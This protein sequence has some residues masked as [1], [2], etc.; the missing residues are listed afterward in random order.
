MKYISPKQFM[1]PTTRGGRGWTAGK[2]R[3]AATGGSQ[4]SN[5][6][7]PWCV[8]EVRGAVTLTEVLVSLFVMGLGVI[9]IASLFPISIVRSIEA[10]Q[11]TQATNLRYN[12]EAQIEVNPDL[13]HDPDRNGV[14]DEHA[15]T[16][17]NIE[18]TN[19]NRRLDAGEDDADNGV[20]G[21]LDRN[22]YV[23]DPLGWA[24][25]RTR[26]APNNRQRL[27]DWFGQR[28][29]DENG[30]PLDSNGIPEL[31]ALRRYNGFNNGGFPPPPPGPSIQTARDF[32]TLPDD[33]NSLFDDVFAGM[34]VPL[35]SNST[36]PPSVG[37]TLL[38]ASQ[39][40]VSRS[41]LNS[42]ISDPQIPGNLPTRLV[43]FDESRT[44]SVT[45]TLTSIGVQGQG[46]ELLWTEDVNLNDNLD[47]GEDLNNN[48]ELDHR[49]VPFA[50]GEVRVQQEKT[51][52]SWLLTVRNMPY[53]ATQCAQVYV[54]VFFNR[55]F[56]LDDEFV[57]ID[58]DFNGNGT[59]QQQVEDVIQNNTFD[60][61][62][63]VLGNAPSREYEINYSDPNVPEPFANSGGFVLDLGEGRWYGIEQ[64][65]N[66]AVTETV[67]MTLDRAPD[68]PI[69][70]AMFPRGVVEVYPL[71]F[72]KCSER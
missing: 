10:T 4:G 60:R 36:A 15:E 9:T 71:R 63:R 62:I 27:A 47:S 39:Q 52:Y 8:P 53:G 41:D 59:F 14:K 51:R 25:I 2:P 35:P 57:Y 43:L 22:V 30:S 16:R 61:E 45:R 34:F 58:E 7:H 54:V 28:D 64:A 13:I 49:P 1:I 5:P 3:N 29:L 65:E 11:L 6:G 24:E 55:S 44:T 69:R 50:I 17:G 72:D 42:T 20:A 26:F 32:V 46:N 66:N 31:Q 67:T 37:V 56:S 68:P 12:A 19:Q 40:T 18:D 38:D 21:F 33:F 23:V 70:H 48:G